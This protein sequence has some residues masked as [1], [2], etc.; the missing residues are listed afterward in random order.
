MGLGIT[1]SCASLLIMHSE[2][3]IIR[4][5]SAIRYF[6]SLCFICVALCGLL[7]AAFTQASQTNTEQVIAFLRTQQYSE[8][9]QLTD[10]LLESSPRDCQLL[11]LRGLALHGV[12]KTDQAVASFKRALQYCPENVLAL[13]G[14]AQIEYDRRRPDAIKLLAAVLAIRPNDI[15][16]HAML[17]ALYRAQE[18]CKAAL[19]HFQA[20]KAIFSAH[21]Q[22]LQGY[23]FCLARLGEYPEAAASYKELLAARSDP[24]DI[25]NYALVQWKMRETKAALETL[26]PLLKM[27]ENE[28]ALSLGAR[29]AEE[30]GDTPQ[31]VALLHS[32][33]LLQPKNTENYLRFA[34]IAFN[35]KSFQVGIDMVNAG[36][37]QLPDDAR[38][39]LARGVL[40]VQVS[41]F[42][43]ALADFKHAHQL[44]PQMSLAMDA[45][46]IMQ[47]QQHKATMS[48][49]LLQREVK[50]HPDDSLLWYLYAEA[51]SNLYTGNDQLEKAIEAAKRS[52]SLDRGYAP[53]HD[54]LALLYLRS[55]Q[56][57]LAA[58]EAEAALKI[59]PNDD[60][61]L[62]H[63]IMAYRR[64]GRNDKVQELVPVLEKLRAQ[65]AE[66]NAQ[67][68]YMLKEEQTH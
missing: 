66:Q 68:H 9:L 15:E 37:T 29:L 14:A 58:N 23:A 19:P 1:E 31:A 56:P 46:G 45:I 16:S 36:L 11:S 48:F 40:E 64:L 35:H 3:S 18:N 2:S 32:A 50:L 42:D 62:Y 38:L 54:M 17:A 24:T 49:D 26:Q 6:F 25:Y 65:N 67:Q 41:H 47:S 8:A 57:L 27:Q 7:R 20:S 43:E 34:E 33:I 59:H 5:P 51:I 61:A 39:Y 63:E 30:T 44:K 28:S 60:T 13:K 21:P 52:V 55:K 22:L 10:S 4:R 53:A 12:D